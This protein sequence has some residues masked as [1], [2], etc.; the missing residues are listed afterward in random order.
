MDACAANAT[1]RPTPATRSLSNNPRCHPPSWR[2]GRRP[3][4]R[5]RQADCL[6]NAGSTPMRA[7]VC[8][9]VSRREIPAMNS[10]AIHR[11]YSS[12]AA[13]TCRQSTNVVRFPRAAAPHPRA[14]SHEASALALRW[15]QR[16]AYPTQDSLCKGPSRVMCR[17]CAELPA[18]AR[19]GGYFSL[20]RTRG[21]KLLGRPYALIAQPFR[22]LPDWVPYPNVFWEILP[23]EFPPGHVTKLSPA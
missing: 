10:T 8:G 14:K 1:A 11:S 19:E 9:R 23:L 18:P 7:L 6:A 3:R 12:V 15:P 16:V 13:K 21:P 5:Q 17:R 20:A 4:R 2:Q 22:L